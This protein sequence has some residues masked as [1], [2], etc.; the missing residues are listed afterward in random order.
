MKNF[1]FKLNFLLNLF[2]KIKILKITNNFLENTKKL[3]K[4]ENIKKHILEKYYKFYTKNFKIN[5]SLFFLSIIFFYYLIYLSFPGI[6]HNKS[7]QNYFTKLLKEQYGLEFSLTPEISYS[8]LPKPHFQI[9]DVIIFNKQ[10]E[11][12]KEIAQVKKLK[13]YLN[14]TNFLKKQKFEISSV[15]LFEANFFI[16]KFDIKF[17]KDYLKKGF[18]KR[19][20]IIKRANLFFQDQ[21]KSTIS[22]LNL[23]KINMH[24]NDRITQDV[25]TSNGEIFNIPF[26]LVWKQDQKKLEQN[27]N[28]KFKKIKL[29]ISNS[30]KFINEKRK[31]KLQIYLNRSRY[32]I[33]Y[34]LDNNKV[35]FKSNNSFIGNNKITFFGKIFLDPFNFDINS[36]LDSIK[37]KKLIS[38]NLFIKEVL[39]KEFILNENFNGMIN[40]DVKNL[41]ENPLFESLNISANFIGETIDFSNSVFLNKK[42]ANLIFKKGILYEEKNNL[43]FKG[44]LEFLINDIDK[45]YNKFVVPKKNRNDLDKLRFE[46][47][48]NLTNS[49]FKILNIINDNFKNK[50]FKEIDDLIYEF[51][52]GGIKI[53][54][55]IEFKIFTNKIISSY[56]G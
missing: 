48:I 24:Y 12:Q 18:Y 34:D 38:N 9:N 49:D 7:D 20:L 46:I 45:L 25:L 42:I 26:N 14:Q 23:K 11:Y 43:I 52:S 19:P 4:L 33:N 3:I 54:N 55:W 22:F 40:L 36:S 50:E 1:K 28:L 35:D 15:E 21:D 39:S 30:T 44:D 10:D 37:I 8:I 16:T 5:Y 53:S 17:I 47:I 41:Q 6:L 27:T 56:S 2:K 29:N 51:N 13:I 32:L 31:N